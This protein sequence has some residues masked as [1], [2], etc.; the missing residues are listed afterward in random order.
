MTKRSKDPTAKATV[1]WGARNKLRRVFIRPVGAA[2]FVGLMLISTTGYGLTL[3]NTD[4]AIY[5]LHITEKDDDWA[6]S[7]GS[8]ET[9]SNLCLSGCSITVGVDADQN[10]NGNELVLIVEGGFQLAK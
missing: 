4:A 3:T 2:I 7:I 9:L 1:E 5:T 6:V 8:K 10:F